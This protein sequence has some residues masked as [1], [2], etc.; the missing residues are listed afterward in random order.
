MLVI[1]CCGFALHSCAQN[2]PS[3]S[4][5]LLENTWSGEYGKGTFTETWKIIDKWTLEGW[6]YYVVESDTVMREYLQIRK[7]GDHWGYLA[8]INGSPPVLFNLKKVEGQS[9]IFAN[10]EHDFPQEIQYVINSNGTLEVHTRGLINGN[11]TV[12]RYLLKPL[13]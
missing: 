13:N 12:D 11:K 7:T 1:A 9:W 2:T 10:P 4:F 8:S 3:D 5:E 6:G